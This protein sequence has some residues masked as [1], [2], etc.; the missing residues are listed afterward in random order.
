MRLA[1]ALAAVFV[2]AACGSTSSSTSGTSAEAPE[3]SGVGDNEVAAPE[4]ALRRF[5]G[6]EVREVRGGVEIRVR[7]D[8]SFMAD[9]EPLFVVDGSPVSPGPGGSLVGIRRADIV[10]IRVLK[11]AS[12][13]SSYGPRGANG[14]I[15]VTTRLA[16]R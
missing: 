5:P 6:V 3:A 7:G 8:T 10:D 14:V 13:T 16:N 4:V 1:L 15:L 9:Q 11:S 12:E 2:L